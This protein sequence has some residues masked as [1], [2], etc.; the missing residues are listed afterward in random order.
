MVFECLLALRERIN[1]GF[2][3][4]NENEMAKQNREGEADRKTAGNPN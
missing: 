1:I 3:I 4:V 2:S